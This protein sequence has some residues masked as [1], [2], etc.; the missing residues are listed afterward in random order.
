MGVAVITEKL[1]D[2]RYTNSAC[3]TGRYLTV[4]N[5]QGVFPIPPFAVRA[6]AV[7]FLTEKFSESFPVYRTALAASDGVYLYCKLIK[8]KLFKKEVEHDNDLSIQ[9]RI[10]NSQSFYPYLVKLSETARLWSFMP[11]HRAG[12]V[13]LLRGW[14]IEKTMFHV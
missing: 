11:E 1:S 13:K 4:Q 14:L 8:T 5:S 10:I 6:E 7:K 12:V 2:I 9:L 3:D